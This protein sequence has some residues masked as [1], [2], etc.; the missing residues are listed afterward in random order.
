MTGAWWNSRGATRWHS[1]L[2]WRK[3]EEVL[4][5]VKA[6]LTDLFLDYQT[7]LCCASLYAHKNIYYYMSKKKI[8]HLSFWYTYEI[9]GWKEDRKWRLNYIIMSTQLS[10]NKFNNRHAKIICKKVNKLNILCTETET[11]THCKWV[12]AENILTKIVCS[13]KCEDPLVMSSFSLRLS[14]PRDWFN[15]KSAICDM[16]VFLM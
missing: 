15:D 5:G 16:Q 7:F 11:T 8:L 14:C 12:I 10:P 6:Q 1:P 13:W 9:E 3:W 2:L 4:K